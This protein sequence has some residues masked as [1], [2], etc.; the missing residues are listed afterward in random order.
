[1]TVEESIHVIFDKFNDLSLKDVSRNAGI[2]ENIEK[3]EITQYD[4]ETQEEEWEG[5]KIGKVLP[6]LGDQQ[7][8]GGNSSLPKEWRF[9]YNHPTNL[10]IS[11]PSRG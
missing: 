11:D 6:Q 2:E 4:K 3:L 5:H 9:V 7:Q 1:M 8:Y 10:I